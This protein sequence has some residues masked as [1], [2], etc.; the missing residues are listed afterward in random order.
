VRLT[1][2]GLSTLIVYSPSAE[3]PFLCLEPVSHP[4][5]AHNLPGQPGLVRLEP[6]EGLSASMVL[7]WHAP[8]CDAPA[9]DASPAL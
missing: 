7:A 4:V 9:Q 8:A 6:G 2:P 1:A 5:D 3:A